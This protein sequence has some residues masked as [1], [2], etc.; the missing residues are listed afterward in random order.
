MTAQCAG[1]MGPNSLIHR[2]SSQRLVFSA[3]IIAVDS[4]TM[5]PIP[6]NAG[7]QCRS[8]RERGFCTLLQEYR[9][10]NSVHMAQFWSRMAQK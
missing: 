10:W 3:D 2:G 9:T 5:M 7:I 4:A 8:S 6:I 1:L